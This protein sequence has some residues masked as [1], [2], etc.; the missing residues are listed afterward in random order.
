[1][2]IVMVDQNTLRGDT[3]RAVAGQ[4][5]A[6]CN[7]TGGDSAGLV[8]GLMSGASGDGVD[9]ALV[10]SEGNAM[11]GNISAETGPPLRVELLASLTRPFAAAVR[12]RLFRLFSP[13]TA[14]SDEIGRCDV[15]LGEEFAAAALSVCRKAGVP[16]EEVDLI[17]SHGQT[18]LH[19]PVLTGNKAGIQT[20][21]AT[22]QIGEP[23]VIAERTQI[24]TV[25]N[26]R[27][28]DMAA[29]GQGAPLVPFVDY[30]LLA[31]PVE[32]R[33]VLN[34]GGIS[35]LTAIPAG[36]D[37]SRVLAFD[38]GP[39]NMVIDELA[40]VFTGQ[41]ADWGGELAG[42]GRVEH[43]WL[44]GLLQ[45]PFYAV[46]PPKSTGRELFGCHFAQA[47]I[48]EGLSRGLP[49]ED[50]VATATALTAHS[51][52]DQ[53]R[54]YVTPACGQ[55][56]R[57]IISGGGA[58]NPV[59]VSMLRGALQ[60]IPV[61]RSDVYGLPV[62]DKEAIAFAI[63]AWCT[64]WNLP[65]NLPAATG[66]GKAVVLGSIT[67]GRRWPPPSRYMLEQ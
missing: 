61:E 45:H 60:G 54:R 5:A 13:E 67:P 40:R 32:T 28:R 42:R 1:M 24:T 39:G 22:L 35:N 46:V 21:A 62:A 48:K 31:H 47:I 8:I 18:I 16:S 34:I 36:L 44:S 23:T 43:A 52:A 33:V 4:N 49:A 10:R 56:V 11:P 66:A 53:I 65:A 12:E 41:Q 9:A 63:L 51:V 30:C 15:L 6:S 2:M 14:R 58:E 20:V 7:R 27:S 64:W 29:G 26:L 19:L 50:I 57:C 38:T 37:P 17:G 55:P 25:S 3:A 59:L